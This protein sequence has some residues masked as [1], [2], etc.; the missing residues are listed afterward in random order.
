MIVLGIESSCDDTSAAV[1]TSNKEILS[2]VVLSQYER[3]L[4]YGGVVPE[5]ASRAHLE[6]IDLAISQALAE[7]RLSMDNV[8]ALAVTVG[9]GL[10]G[11]LLVGLMAAKAISW[12]LNKNLIAIN[13][14]E[15]HALTPRLFNDIPFPF[16]L[17]LVSGGHC[18]ILI[19]EAV[20]K[21]RKIGG[22]ID[23]SLGEAFDKI[24]RMVGLQ[25][26]GGPKIEKLSLRGN[27]KRFHF[28]RAMITTP[29]LELSFSGIKT[30]IKREVDK[31]GKL[32]EQDIA[33]ISASFQEC[34]LD[35]LKNKL[36]RAFKLFK[37]EYPCAKNFVVSGGVSANQYLINNLALLA[38]ESDLTLSSPPIKYC[39]DNA[40]MI[41]W[42]GIE[43]IS[44]GHGFSELNITPK[45][46][47]NLY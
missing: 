18:Q 37:Q 11:G 39:T 46:R 10:I 27:K 15:G 44:A 7:A 13:H 30:A 32:T 21:Y 17:L 16:L 1:V 19:V 14:L 43:K 34:A 42:A 9:P 12:S 36:L 8:D 22:T 6:N 28:P 20:G 24:A 4:G 38:Q 3:H 31:I 29:N 47:W 26:P 5:I 40:A 25:Y 45:A 41:A 33:D 23:D 35:V 2:N